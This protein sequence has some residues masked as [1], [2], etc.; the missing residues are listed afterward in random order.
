MRSYIFLL[1]AIVASCTVSQPGEH[2]GAYKVKNSGYIRLADS[3]SAT[4]LIYTAD[5]KTYVPVNL[6]TDFKQHGLKISFEAFVDTTGL[7]NTRLPGIPV[8]ITKIKLLPKS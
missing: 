4:Y 1:I 8:R 2:K 5:Q 6:E 3:S 7:K